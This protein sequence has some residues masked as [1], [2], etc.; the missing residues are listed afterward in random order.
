VGTN[1]PVFAWKAQTDQGPFRL[2]VSHDAGF[3]DLVLDVTGLRDPVFLPTETLVAGDYQWRWSG[4]EVEGDVLCFSVPEHAVELPVPPVRQWLDRMG[5]DHPRIYVSRQRQREIR[6]SLPGEFAAAWP[7]VQTQAEAILELPRHIDEPPYLPD[8]SLDYQVYIEAFAKAM[9]DSRAFVANSQTLA[10]A[11]VMSG[12]RRY[13]RAA[14]ERMASICRWD[15]EGSTHLAHNDEPHMSVIWHGPTTCDW[16]F[17]EFTDDERA[18][19]I[20]QYRRRGQITFEHMHGR[21]CYGITRFDSHAG[22]EIVFLAMTALAFHEHIPEAETWLEWLRPVLCGI[23]PVW[24][25]ED[26]AWAEGISY[27]LAYVNIMTMFA[28]TLKQGA[29]I[30]LFQ[31]PFWRGHARWRQACFPPYAEWIGFGDHSERWA[32]TWTANADLVQLIGSQTGSS[33]FDQYVRQMRAEADLSPSRPDSGFA[34]LNPLAILFPTGPARAPVTTAGDCL[35]VFPAAGWGAFR[36]HPE[37]AARDI[38]MIVRSSPFGSISHSHA[39]QND[40]ILH[41]GG[42]VLAMPSGYYDGYG[43]PHHANWVWHTKSHNCLTLS[44]AGQIM[45]SHQAAG[46]LARVYEDEAVAY[47]RGTADAAYADRADRCR[48]HFLYL[49]A[50]RCFLLVDEFAATPGIVSTPQWNLHS[51]ARFTTDPEAR[52]FSCERQGARL[53]GFVMFHR[54]GF[55]SLNEGWDPPPR[56]CARD[57]QWHNQYHLRFS[58]SGLPAKLTLGVLLRP[59]TSELPPCP[60]RTALVDG[61]ETASL[62]DDR[63]WLSSYHGLKAE[64][65]SGDGLAVLVLGGDR[66]DLL[67]DGIVRGG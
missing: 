43:S 63:V 44:D 16:V 53:D 39:N 32:S 66:Y 26:G 9:W 7:L 4:K 23:W 50:H 33:E 34:Y 24:S 15:P 2:Q 62:G 37:D 30:D 25:G 58:P 35:R 52:T 20:A 47:V 54:V 38:A 1:P 27:G 8:R 6:Q 51:W 28:V 65:I 22:R 11:Y 61:V 14:C 31:R 45:R 46:A 42:K 41:A 57:D 48:R 19:A 3:S 36:T 67:P 13:A 5:A 10:L 60:V 56:S 21:G 55:F 49:K 18:D 29:D 17:D 40:F 64:H 12:D 59:S